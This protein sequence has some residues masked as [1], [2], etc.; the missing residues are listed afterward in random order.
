ML[1]RQL[2]LLKVRT[3]RSEDMAPCCNCIPPRIPGQDLQVAETETCTVLQTACALLMCMTTRHKSRQILTRAMAGH[4][5]QL[6]PGHGPAGD[7]HGVQ[8]CFGVALL[9]ALAEI[10]CLP[11][12]KEKLVATV[13]STT[14]L[15]G[16][17]IRGAAIISQPGPMTCRPSQ[18][19]FLRQW[20]ILQQRVATHS[21]QQPKCGN[22][23]MA[24]RI[25]RSLGVWKLDKSCPLALCTCRFR[26]VLHMPTCHR[27]LPIHLS[28]MVRSLI[29]IYW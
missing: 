27:V 4:A 10:S 13:T 15:G 2:P 21:S 1:L 9:Q 14:P 11:V 5:P 28:W 12:S 22:I 23:W 26:A 7:A 25:I 24:S 17:L 8:R 16:T 19:T 29:C 20:Q 3:V 18:W 6:M